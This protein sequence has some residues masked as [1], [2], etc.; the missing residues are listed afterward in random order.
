MKQGRCGDHKEHSKLVGNV[1]GCQ[2]KQKE[3]GG[4]FSTHA[5]EMGVL[6]GSIPGTGLGVLTGSIPGTGLGQSNCQS[7]CADPG[8]LWGS[9]AALE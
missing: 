2:R 8:A 9:W 1:G 7:L 6:A 5:A 3:A 4:L